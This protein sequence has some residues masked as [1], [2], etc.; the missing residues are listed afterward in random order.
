MCFGDTSGLQFEVARVFHIRVFNTQTAVYPHWSEPIYCVVFLGD[1]VL[2][3]P[4]LAKGSFVV[5]GIMRSVECEF[6]GKG[7]GGELDRLTLGNVQIL[8]ALVVFKVERS[9]AGNPI[10]H[11]CFV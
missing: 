4:V 2:D 10:L 8:A 1:V 3:G 5:V 7:F 6:T 11:L 9:R